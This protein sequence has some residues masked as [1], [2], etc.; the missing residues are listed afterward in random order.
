MAF[1]GGVFSLAAGNPVVT[2]TTISSTWANN[3]LSDIASNG[4]S[5]CVLKDGTQVITANIPMAQYG[6]TNAGV[7]YMRSTAG[8]TVSSTI[9]SL[10]VNGTTAATAGAH[11]AMFSADAVGSD[12]V[13][14]K[15]RN[16]TIGSHT[17]V[18]SGDALGAITAYGSNGTTFDPAAQILFQSDGTPGAA[19][20]MPGRI[21]FLTTP[22][23]SATPT[24][25]M[26]INSDQTITFANYTSTRIPYFG[27]GGL[28]SSAASLT[29]DSASGLTTANS[30]YATLYARYTGS[31]NAAYVV[32]VEHYATTGSPILINF[33]T[34]NPATKRGDIVYNTGTGLVQYNTSSDYRLKDIYGQFMGATDIIR[35]MRVHRGK[36]KDATVERPMLLAHEAQIVAPYAV[37]GDKDDVNDDGSPRYQMIDH[38][39][40]VPL[41]IAALQEANARIAALE[42]HHGGIT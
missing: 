8:V 29:Y 11:V 40:L 35:S 2:G 20:D 21:V 1:S 9:R 13:F 31:D 42:K 3:T 39:S 23:A 25:A 17:I 7:Y 14:A 10:Q 4:L 37:T 30:S 5:N 6:F 32:Q 41:L 22:N 34:A 36:M 28:L 12:L 19:T 27:A 15:S 26:R 33:L 16:A 38:Q 18:Q 24:E